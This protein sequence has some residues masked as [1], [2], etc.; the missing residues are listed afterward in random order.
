M[1][2][3]TMVS[4]VAAFFGAVGAFPLALTLFGACGSYPTSIPCGT[5]PANGCPLRGG[6]TCDDVTCG[7]IYSCV[8]GNWTL[9]QTCSNPPLE[10][11]GMGADACTVATID[12][13]GE[14]TGC[15]PDLQNPDCP[16]EAAEQCAAAVCQSECIDFFLCTGD[17]WQVVA[18]CDQDGQLVIMP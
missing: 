18:Y 17:G 2:I 14:T 8:D 11:G 13:T 16:V 12:H 4:G 7:A 1:K 15:K 9:A 6:G 10:D 5:I 3:S